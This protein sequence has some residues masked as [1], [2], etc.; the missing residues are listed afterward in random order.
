MDLNTSLMKFVFQGV[1]VYAPLTDSAHTI[2]NKRDDVSI[3][4]FR[5]R[6]KN[7]FY[8]LYRES[9]QL[10]SESVPGLQ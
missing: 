4:F 10:V 6:Q 5:L 9:S 1:Q 2:H 8:P 7:Y 3:H